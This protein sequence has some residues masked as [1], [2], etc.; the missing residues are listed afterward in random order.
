MPPSIDFLSSSLLPAA[1]NHVLAEESWARDL[2]LAHRGKVACI[3]VGIA[4]PRLRIGDD[5]LLE[6]AAADAAPD[7]TISIKLSDLPLIAADRTRAVSYVKIAGDADLAATIARLS[8]SL[9]WDATDDLSRFVGDIAAAR[10]V[11]GAKA[12]VANLQQTQRKVAENLAEYFLEEQPML[13][14]PSLAVEFSAD[15]VRLRDDLER[16]VKRIEKLEKI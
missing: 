13:I 9:R 12:V 14:R 3:D 15:V 2:L 16:L 10:I 1:I 5:G 8:E 6:T 11:S 7:V 4:A